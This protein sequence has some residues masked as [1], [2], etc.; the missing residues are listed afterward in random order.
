[1][2]FVIFKHIN[3]TDSILAD[4]IS[5]LRPIHLYDS[6]YPK[7]EGKEFGHDIFEEHPPINTDTPPVQEGK[8]RK[9]KSLKSMKNQ[10]HIH[11]KI[12]SE[13]ILS[14]IDY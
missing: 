3:D 4:S 7:G 2:N 12:H 8:N 10:P 6:L 13:E 9:R 11:T 14:V 1:M 5:H